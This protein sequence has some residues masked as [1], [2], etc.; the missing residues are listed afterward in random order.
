MSNFR[1]LMLQKD[2]RTKAWAEIRT[3]KSQTDRTLPLAP[4]E[5]VIAITKRIDKTAQKMNF[6]IKD[7]FNKCD[8]IRSFL[9]IW[10]HLL[11]KSLMKNFI[12][13][14]VQ[15]IRILYLKVELW[16]AIAGFC[17]TLFLSKIIH[18]YSTIKSN[19]MK[20]KD[21]LLYYLET[22]ITITY[23]IIY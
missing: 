3:N 22:N 9:Q 21:I 8:Q 13:C 5:K 20:I 16:Q 11:K 2:E 23:N 4:V 12:F 14:A 17:Y 19:K 6:S 10:S 1:D 18:K 15:V 7:F